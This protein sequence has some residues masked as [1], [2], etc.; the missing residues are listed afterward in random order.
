M[1]GFMMEEERIYCTAEE[2]HRRVHMELHKGLR[3]RHALGTGR[4]AASE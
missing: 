3:G 1:E 4:I 2:K